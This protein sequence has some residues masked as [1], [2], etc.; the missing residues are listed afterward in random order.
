MLAGFQ[1]VYDL[2]TIV[3]VGLLGHDPTS[4]PPVVDAP[5]KTDSLHD[6]WAKRW[7]QLLR[8]TFMVFGGKPGLKLGGP[9]G[10][11]V[12]TFAASGMYHE[13]SSAAMGRGFDVR[14]LAFFML[15][16]FLVILERVWRRVTGHRVRGW[17]GTIWVY[18][19]IGVLGQPLGEI[20]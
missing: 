17:G 5:W 10:M 15:Q 7:H 20:Y 6:F 8:Q 13:L 19:V 14:V 18:F 4:W 12:G 3:G 11:V 9:I 16:G 2:V 1:M